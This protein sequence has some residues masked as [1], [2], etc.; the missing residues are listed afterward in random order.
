MEKKFLRIYGRKVILEALNA[1][2]RIKRIYLADY[3]NP[4]RDF[5]NLVEL[6]ERSG[7]PYKVVNKNKIDNLVQGE[8]SQGVVADVEEMRYYTLDEVLDDKDSADLS[9]IL[10]R[11]QDPHNFGAII[12]TAAAVGVDFVVI[13][14]KSSVKV[15][16]AV[17]KVSAALVFRVPIVLETNLT[18]VIDKL[19]KRD[20]WIYGASTGGKLYA[21]ADF[22]YKTALVFGNEGS[23]IRRLILENCDEIISIPMKSGVDSLNVAVSAGIIMYEVLRQRNFQNIS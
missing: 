10:D 22:S 11:I 15:T 7:I 12:R 19:K 6:I 18:R 13:P 21:Q 8:N 14:K 2:V 17:V 3:E 4:S 1:N 23:G 20:F 5:L 16:P 9:I